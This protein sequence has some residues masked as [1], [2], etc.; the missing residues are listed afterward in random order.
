MNPAATNESEYD[1]AV[2]LTDAL[3]Y[4]HDQVIGEARTVAVS[5]FAR[6]YLNRG[7]SPDFL[8][9]LASHA[10]EQLC[11][12]PL[13]ADSV[14]LQVAL[15]TGK[16]LPS[17]LVDRV[18][19]RQKAAADAEDQRIR[20]ALGETL[21]P[22]DTKS[23]L[24][25]ARDVEPITDQPALV[26][27]V[28][29]HR[30]ISLWYGPPGT[31]KT[32]NALHLATCLAL[33]REWF[34][35]KVDQTGVLY[36]AAEGWTGLKNRV[37]G[38][39]Q[40]LGVTDIPLVLTN[41][42]LM[43]CSLNAEPAQAILDIIV[44]AGKLL[45]QPVGLVVIDT[46]NAAFAGGD[47]NSTKDMTTATKRL[48]E[49][50]DRAGVHVV[51]IHHTGKDAAKGARGSSALIA[52]VDSAFEFTADHAIWTRK[53]RDLPEAAPINYELK[54]VEL[55]RKPA[56]ELVTT[57]VVEPATNDRLIPGS[58][59]SKALSVLQEALRSE[60]VEHKGNTVVAAT[61]WRELCK[62][63]RLTTGRT[64]A[65]RQAFRRAKEALAPFIKISSGKVWISDPLYAFSPEKTE[66]FL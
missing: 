20:V 61:R 55:G 9:D 64:A 46:L 33:G 41:T 14:A 45:G 48:M 40:H 32:F 3:I 12:P 15:V 23:N 54:T 44:E 29:T 8:P 39:K 37:A 6:E 21:K 25:L 47:E 52:S 10:N 17:A 51:L 11:A 5:W 57:C 60:G 30:S 26:E 38:M 56:G 18:L 65:E 31:G 58:P 28:I 50:R 42:P 49:I 35:R 4:E 22:G 43:L 36:F 34:G 62:A 53:Q 16:S 24:V 1:R 27:G 7:G 66:L 63:V 2:K 59:A 13:E 19:A